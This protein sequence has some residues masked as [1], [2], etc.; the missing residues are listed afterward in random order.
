MRTEDI[1]G[2]CRRALTVAIENA[3]RLR[4]G[5]PLLHRVA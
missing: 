5:R 3:R 2:G 1:S 4:D